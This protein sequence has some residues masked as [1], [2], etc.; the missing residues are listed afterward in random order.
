MK[1]KLLKCFCTFILKKKF[2]DKII[3]VISIIL[4]KWPLSC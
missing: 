3:N 1:K 4:N 2:K